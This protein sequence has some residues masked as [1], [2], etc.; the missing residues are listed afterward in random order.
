R[1][2]RARLAGPRSGESSGA[3]GS[4]TWRPPGRSARAEL[5]VEWRSFRGHQVDAA[6]GAHGA[7]QCLQHA[8]AGALE[9]LGDHAACERAVTAQ[10]RIH[11]LA[12]LGGHLVGA[13]AQVE[14]EV[15]DALHVLEE[16]ADELRQSLV[17]RGLGDGNVE[18]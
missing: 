5:V 15:E 17:A 7:D 11:E 6:A 1:E 13:I 10:E 12:V 3:A 16:L 9:L 4:G 14:A 18:G 2:D 8:L